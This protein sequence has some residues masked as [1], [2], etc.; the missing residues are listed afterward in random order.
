MAANIARELK[1]SHWDAIDLSRRSDCVLV[2]RAIKRGWPIPEEAWRRIVQQLNE[3]LTETTIDSPAGE[4][5][6]VQR[7]V[8]LCQLVIAIEADNMRLIHGLASRRIVR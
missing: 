7:L 3:L 6:R 8:R 5:K 2:Q 4:S 1:S